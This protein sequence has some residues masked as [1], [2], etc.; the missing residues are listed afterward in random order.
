MTI[1]RLAAN[2]ACAIAFSCIAAICWGW[3]GVAI[4][5]VAWTAGMLL[6]RAM[7]RRRRA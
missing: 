4:T 2:V 7:P 3:Q 6:Y 1:D 5:V